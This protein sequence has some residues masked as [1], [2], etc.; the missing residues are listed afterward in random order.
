MPL[1]GGAPGRLGEAR[2]APGRLAMAEQNG[3]SEA[4]RGPDYGSPEYKAYR[5]AVDKGDVSFHQ[6]ASAWF[7][8]HWGPEDCQRCFGT[9]WTVAAATVEGDSTSAPV[10]G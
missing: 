7:D 1:R 8:W 4:G 9:G 10:P 6:V 3:A 2:A 5:R